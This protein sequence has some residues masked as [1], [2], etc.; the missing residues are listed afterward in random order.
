MSSERK[1][2]SVTYR[3]VHDGYY[4]QRGLKRHAGVWMLWALGVAA[5]I[6]GFVDHFIYDLEVPVF[7]TFRG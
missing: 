4:D 3:D 5:V 2:G 7:G 6:S 1:F